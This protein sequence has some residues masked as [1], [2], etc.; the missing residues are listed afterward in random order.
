MARGVDIGDPWRE[1]CSALDATREPTNLPS[2]ML[3]VALDAALECATRF[4][5]GMSEAL[6]VKVP[7]ATSK[8][9]G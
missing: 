5:Y 9:K 2:V 4:A 7:D 6:G 1:V 8:P 3:V